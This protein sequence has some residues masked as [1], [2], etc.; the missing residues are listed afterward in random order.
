M[1][2]YPQRDFYL[3]NAGDGFVQMANGF[4]AAGSAVVH[5]VTFDKSFKSP[6]V[7]VATPITSLN[8]TVVIYDVTETGFSVKVL[9]VLTA[10]LSGESF[11]WIAVKA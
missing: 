2:V 8:V 5:T 1:P 11:N 7:V 6:P 9:D 3:D 10:A 4:F